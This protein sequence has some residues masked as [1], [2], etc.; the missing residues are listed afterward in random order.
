MPSIIHFVV[1]ALA[2]ARLTQLVVADR[3]TDTP[4]HRISSWAWQRRLRRVGMREAEGMPEPY[5]SYLVQCPWCTS[6]W[7]GAVAAPL[8]YFAGSSPWVFVPALALAFSELSGL[9]A[10]G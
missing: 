4:R 7:I 5:L 10:R 2:V 1:Y 8:I 6:I 9:M 3:I